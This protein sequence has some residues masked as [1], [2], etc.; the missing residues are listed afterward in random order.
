MLALLLALSW[1]LENPGV[2]VGVPDADVDAE[3]A[4]EVTAGD[5][6]VIVAVI[7]TGVDIAHPLL[8]A[9]IAVNA[10]EVPGNGLDDDGNGFIDDVRGWDFADADADVSDA[11]IPHGTMV[12]GLVLSLAPGVRVLPVKVF[13]DSGAD[14]S[15]ETV[16]ADGIRYALDR[17][18]RV[19]QIAWELTGPP[20]ANLAAAFDE[21]AAAG[22]VVVVAAGNDGIDL[23]V[24]P[25]Y[26]ASLQS[27]IAV[28]EQGGSSVSP[29]SV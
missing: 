1:H 20:G 19:L 6:G 12:S 18:A 16:A 23:D 24:T 27:V 22:A 15:F 10:G 21:A 28:A 2:G 29:A 8:A 11:A 17:G 5:A 3:S 4:W 25:R 7:D 14:P 9:S 13:S 26:P